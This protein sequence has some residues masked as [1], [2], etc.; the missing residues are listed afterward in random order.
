MNANALWFTARGAGLG[1]MLVLTLATVLG[2]SASLRMKATSTR[3]V[4]QYVHRTAAVLGLGLIFVHVSTL[5]L[6]SKSHISLA[7]ALVPF[8]AHYRPNSVALGSIAMYLFLFVAA[9]GAAR[10]RIANSARGA[11]AWRALHMISYPAWGIAV[12]HGMLSGTDR[13]QRW[14]VLLTI[15]CVGAVLLTVLIRILGLD[16]DSGPGARPVPPGRPAKVLR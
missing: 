14:V 3:V 10:G 6:D 5:V 1:A 11:A 7:G 4:V 13:S 16:D 15:V 2:A 8:A 9:L 12:L